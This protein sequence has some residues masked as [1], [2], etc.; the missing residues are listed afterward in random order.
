MVY[1]SILVLKLLGENLFKLWVKM[2]ENA[3]IK[4]VYEWKLLTLKNE[5]ELTK[6]LSEYPY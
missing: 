3:V 1:I 2:K 5:L 6:I 4:T